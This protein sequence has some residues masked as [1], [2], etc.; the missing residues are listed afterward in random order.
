[1][2]NVNHNV[3]AL[4]ITTTM[5]IV[6]IILTPVFEVGLIFHRRIRTYILRA[7]ILLFLV[8]DFFIYRI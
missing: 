5:V 8:S 4:V 1:M 6:V 2:I 3:K 7:Y